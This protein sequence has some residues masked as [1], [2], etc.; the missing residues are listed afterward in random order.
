MI[1]K[2]LCN[3]EKFSDVILQIENEKFFAHKAIL[4]SRSEVFKKMFTIG[5]KETRQVKKKFFLNLIKKKKR[6]LF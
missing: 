1:Y 3:N 5:L 6:K 4:I 2:N